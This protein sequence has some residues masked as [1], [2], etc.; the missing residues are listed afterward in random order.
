[1]AE[2]TADVQP[3]SS[4]VASLSQPIPGGAPAGADIRYDDDFQLLKG[5]VDKLGAAGDVDFEMIVS[6]AS[7]LLKE[8]SKDLMT[9]GYLALGLVRT[10]G[11]EGVAESLS[12][13]EMLVTQFWEG[14]HPS[15]LVR[16]RNGLQY[17]IDQGKAF[18]EAVQLQK[19][20]EEERRP[21]EAALASVKVLQEITMRELEDKSPIWSGLTTP[22]NERIR[23]LPPPPEK[24][25]E[26][27]PVAEAAEE[28][29]VE[30]APVSTEAV[31]APAASASEPEEEGEAGPY[32]ALVESLSTPIPGE[33]PTG[34][35]V[36]YDDD[37][38][39]LKTEVD[40]YG[41]AGDVDFELIVSMSTKLLSEK[42]KDLL[43]LSYLTLGLVK[44]KGVEGI[45]ESLSIAEVFVTN[46]WDGVHPQ[47]PIRRRNS[48]QYLI[49]KA[50]D[51]LESIK[52]EKPTLEEKRPLE[53]AMAS[54]KM[55]QDFTMRELQDKAPAWSGLNAVLADRIRIL[56]KPEPPKPD[57]PPE[58]V[59]TAAPAAAA[60]VAASAAPAPPA[61]IE[62]SE[63]AVFALLKVARFLLEQDP[64]NPLP[65]RLQRAYFWGQFVDELPGEGG[66]MFAYAP[67]QGLRDYYEQT[68]QGGGYQDMVVMVENEFPEDPNFLWLASQRM[69]VNSMQN[70]PGY[71]A[72]AEAIMLEVS[73]FV[74][75]FPDLLTMSFQDGVPVAD[76][77]TVEW[78]ESQVMPRFS[79]GGEGGG[80]G[81]G[82]DHV[83]AQFNDARKLL[84]GGDLAGAM[85]AMQEGTDQDVSQEH[86]FRRRFYLAQLCMRGGQLPVARSVL[87]SL[88]QEVARHQLAQWNPQLTLEVW[89]NLYRCYNTLAQEGYDNGPLLDK[90]QETLSKVSQLDASEALAL[91]S[92]G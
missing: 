29:T 23:Y 34:V 13:A 18:F 61:E 81:G 3:Y 86:R 53:A 77:M 71:E 63:D 37:F 6:T 69:L 14:L 54:L 60:P 62:S 35:D 1:M 17:V 91:L 49:D 41:S 31:D 30:A 27:E 48:F 84:G 92:N 4:L 8:K 79:G 51:H 20:G 19:P 87:E 26:P 83:S 9:L 16:R 33:S 10:K 38:G 43:T 70:L 15:K 90:A 82:S 57:P 89:S 47:K 21:L 28:G 56:P 73:A 22:L 67:D 66:F 76:P 11:V 24:P 5:E 55:L 44:T 80:G 88:D 2:V 32:S 42:T 12:L 7:T 65:Y 52:T 39:I 72:A 75:R 64:T 50:K 74:R 78:V 25:A 68:F 46:F 36:K 85:K 59:A 40:D 45:A 58:P